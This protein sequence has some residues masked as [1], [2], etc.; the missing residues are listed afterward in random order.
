[1]ELSRNSA[2]I[3][4]VLALFANLCKASPTV[5]AEILHSPKLVF[6]LR[7]VLNCKD[8]RCIND[9]LRFIDFLLVLLC[10]GRASIS[11]HCSF[12]D[13]GAVSSLD[14]AHRNLIDS[15][16]QRDT[17]ALIDAVE[18]ESVDPNMTDDVGQ[19]LLNWCAAFGTP[20][21][22]IY[23]C[24]KG[25]DPNKG[26]RSSSLHYAACFG[27]AEIVKILLRY[28]ANPD[29]Q[30]EEGRIALDKA[31]ERNDEAHQVVCEILSNPGI[32]MSSS[33]TC[34]A[35]K[36][37]DKKEEKQATVKEQQKEA[38]KIEE[39][40]NI[41]PGL[42]ESFIQQLLPIF[43][44]IFK[45]SL[46]TAIRRVTLT[47]IRKSIFHISNDGLLDVISSKKELVS[48]N[49]QKQQSGFVEMLIGVLIIILESG[50]NNVDA[51]EQALLIIK[52]LLLKNAKF[53]SE[54]LIKLGVYEKIEILAREAAEETT[55]KTTNE[56]E[57]NFEDKIGGCSSSTTLGGNAESTA[58]NNNNN[59]AALSCGEKR[60]ED[61]IS[62]NSVYTANR[63]I[64]STPSISLRSDSTVP[65]TDLNIARN[66][67]NS[68]NNDEITPSPTNE[69]IVDERRLSCSTAKEEPENGEN[70]L[71]GEEE[72]EGV[73]IDTQIFNSDL[74]EAATTIAQA[75]GVQIV[76][77]AASTDNKPEESK[78]KESASTAT[79][80]VPAS[81]GSDDV[82]TLT[83]GV[84][85][86]WRDWRLIR[87]NDS[88]FVWCDAVALELSDGS[89]G[90]LRFLMNGRL[91][92]LYSSGSPEYGAD[93][94]DTRAEFFEKIRK[95]KSSIP[96]GAPS[97]SILSIPRPEKS[98][99]P[100]ESGN[101]LLNSSEINTLNIT[102][103][104]GIQQKM[105]IKDDMPGFVFESSRQQKQM[106]TAESTL[107]HD[108]VTG[109]AARGG[110]R[111]LRYFRV[112]VQKQKVGELAKEI[113]E[114]YLKEVCDRPR[115]AVQEILKCCE[116]LDK[117]A[118]EIVEMEG[119]DDWDEEGKNL[120]KSKNEF[121]SILKKIRSSLSD[122]RQL[123]IFEISISGLVP[124][125]L[126]LVKLIEANPSGI[127]AEMFT[128]I[129]FNPRDLSALVRIVILVLESMEKFPQFLYD[130][131]GG[132]PFG[133]QLL[134]RRL[135]FRFENAKKKNS[136]T[137]TTLKAK[138][139]LLICKTNR[140]LKAEPLVTIAALKSYLNEH[141]TNSKNSTTA[142]TTTT[143]ST[144][145]QHYTR[146]PTAAS[147][148]IAR[149]LPK[150]VEKIASNVS[151]A[152]TN[153]TDLRKKTTSGDNTD[154]T[155]KTN[156]GRNA[157]SI[158]AN[159]NPWST[160][161]SS[162]LEKIGGN[163]KVPT[164]QG[165]KYSSST[166]SSKKSGLTT[167]SQK[168][169]TKTSGGSSR[170]QR[171]GGGLQQ[172]DLSEKTSN[173]DEG[174]NVSQ[175][176]QKSMSTTNLFDADRRSKVNSSAAFNQAA[177][178]ESLQHQTP[179]LENLLSK[180]LLHNYSIPEE[181]MATP[182]SGSPEPRILPTFENLPG[183]FDQR[184]GSEDAA[185][186]SGLSIGASSFAGGSQPV[187]NTNTFTNTKERCHTVDSSSERL[188]EEEDQ[189]QCTESSTDTI[190]ESI[191][192]HEQE[193]ADLLQFMDGPFMMPQEL[194]GGDLIEGE[195]VEVHQSEHT[196]EGD[197]TVVVE[198]ASDLTA[199][200][201]SATVGIPMRDV[202]IEEETS[203]LKTAIECSEEDIAGDNNSTKTASSNTGG[204]GGS[205]H[206]QR[207]AAMMPRRTTDQ[208]ASTSGSGASSGIGNIREKI[209][210]Y[211][212]ILKHMMSQVIEGGDTS[213]E[214]FVDDNEFESDIYDDELL[215][216]YYIEAEC[217]P[218]DLNETVGGGGFSLPS[219]SSGN[220]G[221]KATAI[222]PTSTTT[223]SNIIGDG[224]GSTSILSEA[225]AA[226]ESISQAAGNPQAALAAIRAIIE[227]GDAF[228][229]HIFGSGG[230]S[231]SDTHKRWRQMFS[232]EEILAANS[233]GNI[234]DKTSAGGCARAIRSGG[235]AGNNKSSNSTNNNNG[236]WNDEFVL[237]QHFDALIP[238]FD[239]RPGRTNVN[240]TQEVELVDNIQFNTYQSSTT[241]TSNNQQQIKPKKSCLKQ[242]QLKLYLKMEV[243]NNKKNVVV[244]NVG[245]EKG[246]EEDKL[247]NKEGKMAKKE[248]LVELNDE[249]VSLFKYVQELLIKN[250]QHK[251]TSGGTSLELN[252]Q[253][254][255]NT[256]TI[257]YEINSD[258]NEKNDQVLKQEEVEENLNCLDNNKICGE[259]SNN[260][261]LVGQALE[262]VRILN[263][264][265]TTNNNQQ[266]SLSEIDSSSTTSLSSL[267]SDVFYSAKLTQK[268]CQELADPLV[269]AAKTLPS[270]CNE[271]VYK[272]PCLFSMDTRVMYLN[273]TAFG[274]SRAIAVLLLHQQLVRVNMAGLRREDHYP[275]YRIGRVKHERI[276]VHRSDKLFLE[277]AIKVLKFHATRKS[278]LEIEYYG[279]EGTGLGPTLEFFAL[280]ATEF[281]RKDLYSSSTI[282]NPCCKPPGYYVHSV[283]GLFPAPWPTT[284]NC[285]DDF[286][287]QLELFQ[288]FGIFIAK[289]IQDDRL[290]D[291]P[292]SPV[293]LKL[294]LSTELN[295]SSSIVSVL[296][297]D[298]FMHIFPEKAKL[299]KSLIEYNL[300]IK[301]LNNKDDSEN[302]LVQFG[303]S[304]CSLEDLSL[305]F[306]VN[307]PSKVF[308]Y[309]H[310]E[311]IENGL[312]IDV[313]LE[314]V[315]LYIE[316][317]LDFYLN[318]G[319]KEQVFAFKH[320]FNMV[321]PLSSLIPFSASELQLLIS[322][323]QC[324]KWTREDLL[325]YTEPKLGYT[326]DSPV[327]INFVDVLNNFD[328]T[329]R[330]AF[331]QFTT[332]C[333][334]L[335][336]G[337]LA[338]LHPR[339]TI[340]RK[341]GS[342]DGSYPSVN[343][344]VHYLKLPEYSTATILRERL[345]AATYEKGFHLN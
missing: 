251:A 154:T 129:F 214:T 218:V 264:L 4:A 112:E 302:I 293:F 234:G 1:M 44:T 299:L 297:L 75:L 89:N 131:P 171:G 37:Q 250:S 247:E 243:N 271:L 192:K 79:P 289:A 310:A 138:E 106:F 42:A 117:L 71:I 176:Q 53:W 73:E 340:V 244:E 330:K 301:E 48:T 98:T 308:P 149:K 163:I 74:V 101:W 25:A 169:S 222:I 339:L 200:D 329:E 18:N 150:Y 31:R 332:G 228:G 328:S 107:G 342:G 91:S 162:C 224:I 316:K 322:G 179:S 319:I 325:R 239:P 135:R 28:G 160:R 246:S 137:T 307:P 276:K 24:D 241:N 288:L 231:S 17:D 174:S 242:L 259:S 158:T 327:F 168:S 127:L 124:A 132:S 193:V 175:Q 272:F 253:L 212:D 245:E 183:R 185:A 19:T 56:K 190:N 68:A 196:A 38:V 219:D 230:S 232:Q 227:R 274:T 290:V 283:G 173:K 147:L 50:E 141:F 92:T 32:Y 54:Q 123:S 237:R 166:I 99:K 115:E 165:G 6:A 303:D 298:D 29:L 280:I 233:G 85:Y 67:Q 95:A 207:K 153:I 58:L 140:S 254:W 34:A 23:L 3:S 344:C 187:L 148:R 270:W 146:P 296:D 84:Y 65:S 130:C 156:N 76:E 70:N 205:R 331:L 201:S 204:G 43:C 198:T 257:I 145:L 210:S 125:L 152:A 114:N 108:F 265:A 16:R 292:L 80:A 136:G 64:S 314:N 78:S 321:L 287:K 306:A 59:L 120:E 295:S 229:G 291:L 341:V 334:S 263:F 345:L 312:N 93:N 40:T 203:S 21:M 128:E 33:I 8:E 209:G 133:F 2:F 134:T 159:T 266:S 142:T 52:S 167:G 208:Q 62:T 311:L 39:E 305:T 279:E 337:G 258:K 336:P 170:T 182:N 143:T 109:W 77:D 87:A 155:T 161:D 286:S 197:E 66:T 41:D 113:W 164:R 318:T 100:L 177:S 9:C 172:K 46:S 275:E 216:Q 343:T 278:I 199:T 72:E 119:K 284:T 281:Q 86:R 11:K 255:E 202:I 273:T 317:C 81:A 49:Q 225:V 83:P 151:T 63:S 304:E 36:E 260:V 55:T 22:V 51:K 7:V 15:I 61:N 96:V 309:S 323:E 20:D 30:D 103:K 221:E 324:P 268:L 104:E 126:N 300:K 94:A 116:S 282:L 181:S 277:N 180:A 252:N 45:S 111:R 267:K 88:L 13:T 315:E 262:L 235:G 97:H 223:A 211:T 213:D 27:R 178:A 217:E 139:S 122:D 338:N 333:S 35:L 47:L 157:A 118:N 313:T 248:V 121:V 220:T 90:W 110:G 57:N 320:G 238:A 261:P 102:N 269:V 10:E 226:L 144:N 186:Q 191:Q 188:E 12:T 14:K 240:Q 69:L 26:L 184:K 105:T 294:I 335:P 189:Q 249:N 82:W 256:Y 326:R 285:A 236:G 215:N 60:E 194:F 206:S 5:T 195:Q